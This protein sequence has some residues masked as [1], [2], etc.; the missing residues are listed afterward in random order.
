MSSPQDLREAFA[1][2]LNRGDFTTCEQLAAKAHGYLTPQH[3]LVSLTDDIAAKTPPE[4]GDALETKRRMWV[5]DAALSGQQ[6]AR[7][8]I[9]LEWAKKSDPEHPDSCWPNHLNADDDG[10]IPAEIVH[11]WLVQVAR[12]G[13]RE[14]AYWAGIIDANDVE[15]LLT[16]YGDGSPNGVY[17]P[18]TAARLGTHYASI[19]SNQ[20][21]RWFDLAIEVDGWQWHEWATTWTGTIALA[22]YIRWA[23]EHD[24]L[25]CGALCRL[26]VIDTI[27]N[28]ESDRLELVEEGHK[29]WRL[30]YR[31]AE[32]SEAARHLALQHCLKAHG[33]DSAGKA[34]ALEA[35]VDNSFFCAARGK[36]DLEDRELAMSVLTE[37][38]GAPIDLIRIDQLTWK[39]VEFILR[40]AIPAILRSAR[41][42]ADATFIEQEVDTLDFTPEGRLF[43]DL[44]YADSGMTRE[45]RD[46]VDFGL[47]YDFEEVDPADQ[48]LS[49]DRQVWHVESKLD[50][51]FELARNALRRLLD[52]TPTNFNLSSH[53]Y[54]RDSEV[55]EAAHVLWNC[56]LPL[57]EPVWEPGKRPRLYYS[58]IFWIAMSL[59]DCSPPPEGMARAFSLRDTWGDMSGLLLSA[60]RILVRHRE[61]VVDLLDPNT[62]I[63]F[64][65]A[66]KTDVEAQISELR[67]LC[68][69][70]APWREGPPQFFA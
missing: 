15:S 70:G 36:D 50:R 31:R 20:A 17:L 59:A 5:A 4:M 8:R 42:D 43:A 48:V 25:L 1:Q 11:Q 52:Q 38:R 39:F 37:I 10:A 45:E 6:W 27:K 55:K 61:G 54:Q 51:F 16:A 9:A 44:T 3:A 56:G 67:S 35:L 7:D 23:H 30:D 29:R 12:R 13:N 57:H 21:G 28:S 69:T 2:A 41:C 40:A 22:E 68:G 14:A 60:A 58:R 24:T 32:N 26:L 62:I 18:A 49:A 46:H 34:K 65:R 63:Q 53:Y 19:G 66:L 64:C 47:Y 33:T